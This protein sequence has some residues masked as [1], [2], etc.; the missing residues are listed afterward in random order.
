MSGFSD[1]PG[2]EPE[3]LII[4]ATIGTDLTIPPA[5]RDAYLQNH[6][7]Q[8]KAEH[9]RLADLL[10]GALMVSGIEEGVQPADIEPLC[11]YKKTPRGRSPMLMRKIMVEFMI[12]LR[13]E[14]QESESTQAQGALSLGG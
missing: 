12:I 8:V 7:R 1:A 10:F 11:A 2:D 6:A 5:E 14:R 3:P 4:S 9:R 13:D